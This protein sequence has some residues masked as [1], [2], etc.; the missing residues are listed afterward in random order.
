M[1]DLAPATSDQQLLALWKA[2]SQL[3]PQFAVLCQG[4]VPRSQSIVRA[5]LCALIQAVPQRLV[6]LLRSTLTLPPP[7]TRSEP[8]CVV[9]SPLSLP[10]RTCW[11]CC[12]VLLPHKV[13]AHKDL[14]RV[15]LVELRPTMANMRADQAAAA[16]RQADLDLVQ[17]DG[18]GARCRPPCCVPTTIPDLRVL[19]ALTKL[20]DTARSQVQR[21][22]LRE[23]QSESYDELGRQWL[24]LNQFEGLRREAP[25]LK[26]EC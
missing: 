11:H 5:E 18:S 20:V 15:P 21:E 7:Y 13:A 6:S 10:T 24:L 16:A 3:P 17:Q 12:R 25:A 22:E 14:D 8:P 2:T 26:D 9:L 4:L 23:L 19:I 1:V